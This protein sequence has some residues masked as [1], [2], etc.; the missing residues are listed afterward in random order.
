MIMVNINVK[1][2]KKLA[3]MFL[4]TIKF[5]LHAEQPAVKKYYFFFFGK[6]NADLEV[7]DSREQLR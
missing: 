3:C 5:R 2:K 7:L 4:V 6:P 1:K